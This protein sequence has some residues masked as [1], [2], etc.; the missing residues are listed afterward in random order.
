MESGQCHSPSYLSSW[1][2]TAGD[3]FDPAKLHDQ[4]DQD[5]ARPVLS[6]R[7]ITSS[8]TSLYFASRGRTQERKRKHKRKISMDSDTASVASGETT[9]T[10]ATTTSA[11]SFQNRPILYPTPP[12]TRQRSPSPTR[13]ILSQLKLATPSLRVCQPDVRVEQPPAVKRLRSM[14][15]AKLSSDVIPH[16]LEVVVFPFRGFYG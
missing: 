13:K 5:L 15:I 14:L 1:L 7:T 6:S 12:S 10:R 2:A 16:S 9:K 3:W 4:H 8:S 11:T